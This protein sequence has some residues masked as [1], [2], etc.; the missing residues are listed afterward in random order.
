MMSSR[1]LLASGDEGL[2]DKAHFGED[3]L[4]ASSILA[5]RRQVSRFSDL[6]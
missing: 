2:E 5:L 4:L 1:H 6:R 3:K